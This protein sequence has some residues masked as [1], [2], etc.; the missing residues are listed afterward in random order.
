MFL[1][2][3]LWFFALNDY[4]QFFGGC[5]KKRHVYEA[6]RPQGRS[7]EIIELTFIY[8]YYINIFQKFTV[9]SKIYKY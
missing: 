4:W 1:Q 5:L 2:S 3:L 7:T 8:K 9:S 6:S